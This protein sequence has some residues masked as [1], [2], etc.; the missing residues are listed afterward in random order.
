MNPDPN[1]LHYLP[2]KLRRIIENAQQIFHI[3]KRKPS[4]LE[5]SHIMDEIS[6][7]TSRLAVVRGSDPISIEAQA[8]ATV[9]FNMHLRSS[10]ATRPVLEELH[11]NRQA[12]D[13]IIGEIETKF[14]APVVNPGEMCGTLVAQPIG[15]PATQMT[16]NTFHYAGVSSKNVTL[17]APRLKEIINVATNIK[18]PSLTVYLQ[19]EYG[20]DKHRAKTI[21]T[22]LAHTTLCTITAATEIIHDPDPMNT[23]IDEDRDFVETLFFFIFIIGYLLSYEG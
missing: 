18:I 19:P 17:G 15:E 1:Q 6:A 14:N 11:L 10:F 12:F 16:L 5:P 22:E 4:D 8:N 21:Q 13:W 3:D 23:I 9:L 20:K 2:V 7:L